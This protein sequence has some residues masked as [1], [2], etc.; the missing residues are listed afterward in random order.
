MGERFP[1]T[2]GT[3]GGGSG[4]RRKVL[5]KRRSRGAIAVDGR[6]EGGIVVH[7]QLAVKLET[8]RASKGVL[9]KIIKAGSEICALLFKYS[10]TLEIALGVINGS[11]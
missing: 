11:G 4:W 6:V 9:P 7:L 1:R 3:H 2:Q 5:I 8:A 10:E